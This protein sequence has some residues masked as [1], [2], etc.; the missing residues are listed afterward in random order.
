MQHVDVHATCKY[1]IHN[2]GYRI[3]E[4]KMITMEQD[5]YRQ[6]SQSKEVE[7]ESRENI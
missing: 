5:D 4:K 1:Y 3:K 6:V 2:N 7:L